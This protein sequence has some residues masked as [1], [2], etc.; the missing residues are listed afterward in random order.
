YLLSSVIV[1]AIFLD[2]FCSHMSIGGGLRVRVRQ[3]RLR[4]AASATLISFFSIEEHR[5]TYR[6]NYNAL[7]RESL[8]FRLVSPVPV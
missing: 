8:F 5:Y 4:V 6:L 2:D 7:T 3:R 1:T